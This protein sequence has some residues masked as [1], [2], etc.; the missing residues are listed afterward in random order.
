MGLAL[1]DLNK[2]EKAAIHY[3]KACSIDPNDPDIHYNRG[4]NLRRLGKYKEA[5]EA[6][7]DARKRDATSMDIVYNMAL[8]HQDLKEYDKAATLYEEILAKAKNHQHALNNYAYLCH[9]KND[10]VKAEQLYRRLLELN[11]DHSAAKH[12]LNGLCGITTDSAPLEYVESVFDTYADSFEESLL[13]ELQYQTPEALKE[14]LFSL[15]PALDKEKCLDLGCGTGLAGAAFKGCCKR[16]TGVDISDKILQIAKKKGIYDALIK[17]DIL[18][19]LTDDSDTYSLIIAADVFTYMGDLEQL[20]FACRNR[21]TK[22]GLFC[23]SVEES[24]SKTYNLKD[25]G[26][27]GHALDYIQSLSEK[28][29]WTVH[30]NRQSRLRLDRNKWISGFLFVLQK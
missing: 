18:S 16:L 2:F 21:C 27:F 15:F 14:L 17:D 30:S 25:T 7:W 10:F 28:T 26:R 11:P 24:D 12:M 1:F 13:K 19:F 20:F 6:F 22:S 5:I 29:G 8:S 3:D 9:K 4:L 23:F